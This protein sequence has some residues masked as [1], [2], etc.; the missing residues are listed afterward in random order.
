V[1]RHRELGLTG[2][3]AYYGGYPKAESAKW[4]ALARV[5]DLVA[6]GGSD[7]HGDANPAVTQP[8]VNLEREVADRLLAWLGVTVE[9]AA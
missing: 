3:E 9:P 8:G 5:L 4:A 1:A 2:I 6:T 7:F